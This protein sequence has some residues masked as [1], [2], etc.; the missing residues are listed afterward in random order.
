MIELFHD[1]SKFSA[2]DFLLLGCFITYTAFYLGK[3]VLY[4]IRYTTFVFLVS[5]AHCVLL[6]G[7]KPTFMRKT[8]WR[9]TLPF[10]IFFSFPTTSKKLKSSSI[11][12]AEF[13]INLEKFFP[14]LI[15]HE[16]E[17]QK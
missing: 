13:T 10:Q 9:F 4:A 5:Y 14:R 2:G 16:P 3:A 6:L 17:L 7:V 11:S 12:Y 15:I 1:I 8:M